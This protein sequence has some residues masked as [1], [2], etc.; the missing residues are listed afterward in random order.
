MVERTSVH[1]GIRIMSALSAS[2]TVLASCATMPA[3][4]T[5]HISPYKNIHDIRFQYPSSWMLEDMSKNYDSLVDAEEEGASYIQIYSYD[6]LTAQNPAEAISS[7]QIKIAIIL[8]KR[9]KELDYQKLLA[10]IGN[11][12]S[13]KSLFRINGSDAYEVLYEV[14]NEESTEKLRILSIEYLDQDLYVKFICY[15]WN[16]AHVREFEALARSFRYRGK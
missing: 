1:K 8:K 11:G 14:T 6:P 12:V 2:V 7:T 13:E 9:T 5:P 4:E 3:P 16:S 15:P 10:G